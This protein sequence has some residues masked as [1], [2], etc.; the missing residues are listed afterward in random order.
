MLK[1]SIIL[2]I[3]GGIRLRAYIMVYDGF[4]EFEITLADY[5]IK[6][7]GEIMTVGVTNQLVT[8]FEG[9]QM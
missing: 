3:K 2:Q 5:F 9:M 6:T 7:T 8:S 4:T 1:I